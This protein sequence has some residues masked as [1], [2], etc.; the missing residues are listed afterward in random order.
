MNTDTMQVAYGF[1]SAALMIGA[2]ILITGYEVE[3]DVSEEMQ[4][5]T[6]LCLP[7]LLWAV[8]LA[9]AKWLFG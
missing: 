1:A 2:C 3:H 8:V 7:M 9:G 4:M 6:A 5:M